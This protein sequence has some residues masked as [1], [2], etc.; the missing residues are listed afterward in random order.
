M[1]NVHKLNPRYNVVS[2]RVTDAEKAALDDIM[3]RTNKNLSKVMREAIYLYS[4]D[5]TLLSSTTGYAG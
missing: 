1:A 4:R 3:R 5:V 2:L